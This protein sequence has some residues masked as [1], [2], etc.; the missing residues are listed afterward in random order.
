MRGRRLPDST[1]PEQPG[2][3]AFFHDQPRPWLARGE[4]LVT[5]VFVK[6][7]NGELFALI[8]EVHRIVEHEDGTISAHPS[9]VS[10]SHRYHG[11][12]TRGEWS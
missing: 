6:T 10:P 1:M 11:M 5:E 12:L 8:P 9:V 7:P 3:Y 4:R 2:D